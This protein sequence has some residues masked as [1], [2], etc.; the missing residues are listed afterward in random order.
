MITR[1]PLKVPCFD[2]AYWVTYD[3]RDPARLES[4]QAG[5]LSKASTSPLARVSSSSYEAMVAAED[6]NVRRSTAFAR[7]TLRL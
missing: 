2:E 6:E 3:K 5:V 4:F 1:D 7:Q